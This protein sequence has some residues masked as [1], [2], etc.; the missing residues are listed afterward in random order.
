MDL[1]EL[2]ILKEWPALFAVLVVFKIGTSFILDLLKAVKPN[3]KDATKETPGN[4]ERRECSKL[5][6]ELL[7]HQLDDVFLKIDKLE[8][9]FLDCPGR[10]NHN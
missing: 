3:G 8:E 2:E 5:Q 6:F 10:I 9:R 7:N 4:G 1:T